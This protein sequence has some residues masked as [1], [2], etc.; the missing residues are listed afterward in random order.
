MLTMA[1]MDA[2]KF[3]V[4]SDCDYQHFLHLSCIFFFSGSDEQ[5]PAPLWYLCDCGAVYICDELVTYTQC[6]LVHFTYFCPPTT[7]SRTAL[8]PPTVRKLC[9]R[10]ASNCDMRL[11]QNFDVK[12]AFHGH[13]FWWRKRY[14]DWELAITAGHITSGSPHSK[15][16]GLVPIFLLFSLSQSGRTLWRKRKAQWKWAQ[17]WWR[18]VTTELSYIALYWGWE[19]YLLDEI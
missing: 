15:F 19:M 18:D 2:Q 7:R 4:N 9:S 17:N 13:A 12:Y 16:R 11:G 5:H 3:T 6:T 1:L 14:S 10:P 8:F